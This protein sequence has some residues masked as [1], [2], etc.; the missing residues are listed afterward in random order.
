LSD[1]KNPQKT[2]AI[3]D[4]MNK[5]ISTTQFPLTF[6]YI[7]HI[8]KLYNDAGARE[9]TTKYA[10]LGIQTC[11]ELLKNPKLVPDLEKYEIIGNYL[12]PYRISAMLYEMLGDYKAATDRLKQLYEKTAQIFTQI[13]D[14]PQ[15]QEDAQKMEFKLVDLQA[16]INDYTLDAQVQA[17]DLN[18]AIKSAKEMIIKYND[19]TSQVMIYLK[20]YVEMKLKELETKRDSSIA[21]R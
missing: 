8:A 3:L 13:K 10:Q 1:E 17:G 18:G 21:R 2:I 7:Y 12:G 16:T 15:Y 5:Y 20:R 11:D 9:Q 6:D 14:N 4:T 19:T